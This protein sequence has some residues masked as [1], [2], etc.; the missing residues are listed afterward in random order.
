MKCEWCVYR[1]GKNPE[2][3]EHCSLNDLTGLSR[4]RQDLEKLNIFKM[5][6][7]LRDKETQEGIQAI[8]GKIPRLSDCPKCKVH[9]LSFDPIHN[10]FECLN[11][12]CAL[13]GKSISNTSELFRQI[14]IKLLKNC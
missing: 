11:K 1:D 9:S 6:K 2:I 4:P 8:K 13:F 7:K 10:Q 12:E 14:V 5:A 3:C